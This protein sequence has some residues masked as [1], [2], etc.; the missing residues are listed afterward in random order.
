MSNLLSVE[1]YEPET[2]KWHHGEDFPDERKFTSVAQLGSSLYVCGGVRQMMRR[3]A[4][5]SR[6]PVSY[7]HL[8]LPTTLEV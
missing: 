3:S 1:V 8:T 6:R 4:S 5:V 7:T 2:N